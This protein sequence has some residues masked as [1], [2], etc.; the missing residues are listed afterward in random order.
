[1]VDGKELKNMIAKIFDAIKQYS[2]IQVMFYEYPYISWV[3]MN[4]SISPVKKYPEPYFY[5]FEIRKVYGIIEVESED[6][7]KIR[8]KDLDEVRQYLMKSLDQH[9]PL[10]IPYMT[11]IARKIIDTQ[12]LEVRWVDETIFLDKEYFDRLI[13]TLRLDP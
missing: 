1:M 4:G 8:F 9:F 12:K 6:Y 13:P 11:K 7:E 3:N 5:R 10:G 2:S